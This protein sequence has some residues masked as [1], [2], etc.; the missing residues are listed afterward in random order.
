MYI[1]YIYNII[2]LTVQVNNFEAFWSKFCQKHRIDEN[3]DE[4]Y[5]KS[6]FCILN[7]CE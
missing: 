6:I 4:P 7:K 5:L 1:M 2:E 3:L